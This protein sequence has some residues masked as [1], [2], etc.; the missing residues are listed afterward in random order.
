[1]AAEPSSET[2]QECVEGYIYSG[3]PPRVLLL[4]RPPARGSIWAPVSGKVE[5]EDADFPAALRREIAEETRISDPVRVFDLGWEFPFS[6]PDGRPWRLHGYGVE[7]AGEVEPLLSDE[8]DAFEW[9]DPDE[10]LNRLHYD[11]NR[12]ALRILLQ[13]LEGE[14][15]PAA[16]P[17]Y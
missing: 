15:R 10:A 12:M 1:V 6:G 13:I 11:D 14:R 7:L 4:R 17:S 8:H 16:P 9:V 2:E 3:N 5:P